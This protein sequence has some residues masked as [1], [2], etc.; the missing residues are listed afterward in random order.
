ML[1][2]LGGGLAISIVIFFLLLSG[3]FESFTLALS[4]LSTVPPC[5]AA[6]SGLFHHRNDIEYRVVHGNDHG[7]RGRRRE[8]NPP[9]DLL[10]AASHGN[11]RCRGGGCRG[12]AESASA[13]SDDELRDV[14]RHDPDGHGLSEGG[15][16]SS[17]LGRAVMGGLSGWTLATL[18]IVPLVFV[19]ISS[20][21]AQDASLDPDDS[22]DR[23]TRSG[24]DEKSRH[25]SPR[26]PLSRFPVQHGPSKD[27]F[28]GS[29]AST[30]FLNSPR[31]KVRAESVRAGRTSLCRGDSREPSG[32]LSDLGPDRGG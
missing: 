12:S 15:K 1:S 19:I 18:L 26:S 7:D 22:T 23:D 20:A 8:L 10:R 5:S 16:Q 31:S 32:I 9:R 21:S 14:D 2:G 3:D 4:I 13:N 29:W 28:H 27:A 30:M 6:P 24:G 11:G 25:G 17:P